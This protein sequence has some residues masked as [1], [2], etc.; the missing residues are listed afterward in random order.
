MATKRRKRATPKPRTPA[1]VRRKKRAKKVR[2]HQHPELVGLGLTAVGLFLTTVVYF[3]WDGGRVGGWIAD[4]IETVIGEG[5]YALPLGLAG[6]GVLMLTRSAIVELRPFRTGMTVTALGLMLTLGKHGGWIGAALAGAA[7]A[8]LGD[9]GAAIA[10]ITALVAGLLLL[11]G[12][13]AGAILRRSGT[14][15]RATA[16]AARAAFELGEAPEI[17]STATSTRPP[18]DGASEFPDVVGQAGPAPLIPFPTEENAQ[19][20]ETEESEPDQ[21]SLF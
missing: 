7:A 6:V 14:A 4:A 10:G 11:T 17:I 12:A 5:V 20:E 2:G 21:P 9:T 19:P 1:R 16:H 3:E 8:L 18:V 13:S 15:V